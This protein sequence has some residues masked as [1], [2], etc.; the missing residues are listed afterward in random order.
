M[1]RCAAALP[2]VIPTGAQRK[3]ATVCFVKRI[4]GWFGCGKDVDEATWET[5]L[6]FPLSPNAAAAGYP[7]KAKQQQVSPL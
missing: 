7:R 6:R 2:F 5:R 1:P 4:E 3:G